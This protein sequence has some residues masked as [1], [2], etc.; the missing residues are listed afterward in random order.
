M[1]NKILKSLIRTEIKNMLLVVIAINY[2]VVDK[3]SKTFNSYLGEDVIYNFINSMMKESKSC[4]DIMRKH[5][6]KEFEMTK[7]A[8]KDFENST[9]CW[10]CD[11]TYVEG[12]VKVRHNCHITGKYSGPAHRDCNIKI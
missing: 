8:D 1:K 2:C 6:N 3:F 10:I 12:D 7:E 9:K 4:T 5:F 11:H